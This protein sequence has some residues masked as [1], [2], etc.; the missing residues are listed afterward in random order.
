LCKLARDGYDCKASGSLLAI[1]LIE[2]VVLHPADKGFEI[3][4][5][6]EIAATVDLGA[7]GGR[8]GPQPS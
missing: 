7:Q 5:V 2:R 1:L 6:G 8:E 4:L 3:E